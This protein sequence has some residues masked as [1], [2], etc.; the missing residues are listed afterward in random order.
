MPSKRRVSARNSARILNKAFVPAMRTALAKTPQP[1][2]SR[3]GGRV[4]N[5]E[6]LVV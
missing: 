6:G 2:G 4:A 5:E 1:L 3:N